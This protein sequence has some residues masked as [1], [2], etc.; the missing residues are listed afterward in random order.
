MT[1]RVALNH[2][3]T[4]AFDR[5]VGI[6]PHVVRLRPAPHSRTPVTA[7]SL[8]VTPDEHFLNWQQD[9]FGNHLARLVF[10]ERADRAEHRGR[11]GRR[12]DRRS[13]PSTSSSSRGAETFPF[14]YDAALADDLEPY[15]R[16]V[17]RRHRCRAWTAQHAGEPAS[18]IVD[19]LV[20]LNQAVA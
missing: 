6:G 14:R 20:A 4:Y 19:F 15:L 8:R 16:P 5:L 12:P 17:G 13:T 1:I 3:T 18:P 11:P 9:P 10:P 7:Y 2:R